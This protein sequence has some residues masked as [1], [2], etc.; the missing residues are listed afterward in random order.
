MH[1]S[2]QQ[3]TQQLD[4]SVINRLPKLGHTDIVNQINIFR[5]QRKFS[6]F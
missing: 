1:A 6:L 5:Y 3:D 4:Q 2:T